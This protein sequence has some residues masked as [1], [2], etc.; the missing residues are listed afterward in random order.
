M[1]LL[2]FQPCTFDNYNTLVKETEIVCQE[3][4]KTASELDPVFLSLDLSSLNLTQP[5]AEN[6]VSICILTNL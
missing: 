1:I 4:H 2:I 3:I 5:F 6:N